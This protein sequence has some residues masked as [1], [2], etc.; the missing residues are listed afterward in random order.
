MAGP[1]F[2]VDLPDW[3]GVA[4]DVD[5]V[6]TFAAKESIAARRG[7]T[8][9]CKL[10]KVNG[11]DVSSSKLKH[12]MTHLDTNRPLRLLFADS[13]PPTPA[14]LK[15]PRPFNRDEPAR[16]KMP[17]LVDPKG[18]GPQNAADLHRSQQKVDPYQGRLG[19]DSPG[20]GIRTPT[21]ERLVRGL[22]QSPSSVPRIGR[23]PASV[24]YTMSKRYTWTAGRPSPATARID[25]T[26]RDFE[27]D[28]VIASPAGPAPLTE[29]AYREI[30]NKMDIDRDGY[31][32][33][34]EMQNYFRRVKPD[35]SP[36]EV[37]D[38][39]EKMKR[40]ARGGKTPSP[41]K[42]G[43]V[44]R[45][46]F[47]DFYSFALSRPEQS[48]LRWAEKQFAS[49]DKDGD[50]WISQEE[51]VDFLRELFELRPSEVATLNKYLQRSGVCDN[52]PG[53]DLD[54]FFTLTKCLGQV[55]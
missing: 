21:P 24:L 4:L 31:I 37:E 47:D 44:D 3:R 39:F 11:E 34:L 29:D 40:Q 7:V 27:T 22:I 10:L 16:R 52:T 41:Q 50:G 49:L 32:S 38:L 54:R 5:G 19:K 46:S 1:N 23:I 48:R 26:H 8:L 20:G 43:G 18:P 2:T 17:R 12:I 51:L 15:R 13:G 33:I 9:G 35:V 42:P 30:F 6:V 25:Y 14:S 28:T 55:A 45:V 53:L 36:K